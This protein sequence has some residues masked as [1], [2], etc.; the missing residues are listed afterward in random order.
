[1]TFDRTVSN[2][3]QLGVLVVLLGGAILSYGKLQQRVN[4]QAELILALQSSV[5][6][7][8]TDATARIATLENTCI[9]RK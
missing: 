1:M 3:A 2:W 6:Q 5:L 7:H 8:A 4:D 9:R